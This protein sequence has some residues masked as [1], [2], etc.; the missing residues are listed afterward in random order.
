M[1]IW[2]RDRNILTLCPS[3][4]LFCELLKN[5][6]TKQLRTKT[7]GII[8][9]RPLKK[10]MSNI[11]NHSTDGSWSYRFLFILKSRYVILHYKYFLISIWIT[12]ILYNKSLWTY[13]TRIPRKPQMNH[14][15]QYFI[16]DFMPLNYVSVIELFLKNCMEKCIQAI[17][18]YFLVQ[19]NA[20]ETLS[21]SEIYGGSRA[22]GRT[23]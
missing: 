15:V 10:I 3:V 7:H 22:S 11:I 12:N 13:L 9:F 14:L 16:I 21:L 19:S 4:C 20:P 6:Y 23:F 2:A 5:L 18:N 1:L 17:L 8:C